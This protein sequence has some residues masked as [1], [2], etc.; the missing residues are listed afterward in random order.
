MGG[1]F[2]LG[3]IVCFRIAKSRIQAADNLA[4]MGA[5]VSFDVRIALG[6]GYKT[7]VEVYAVNSGALVKLLAVELQHFETM[8]GMRVQVF[9]DGA[10][11]CQE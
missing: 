8:V 4:E 5:V 6:H 7:L 1:L 11:S 3:E 10:D 2:V 9:D